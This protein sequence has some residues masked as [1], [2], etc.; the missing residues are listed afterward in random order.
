MESDMGRHLAEALVKQITG[1]DRVKV[2]RLYADPF[3]ILP[4]FKIFLSTNHRPHIRGSDKAIW[5]RLRLI[6]F[7]VV[8]PD[9]EQ[10]HRLL[11]T[12]ATETPG[13]LAWA[14][15]G[16]LVWQERGLEMPEEVR[17]ATA[18][19]RR[20]EDLLAD[21]LAERCIVDPMASVAAADLRAAYVDWAEKVGEKPL[22][23][24]SLGGHLKE[25]GFEQVRTGTLRG[26]VG[27]RLR[28]PM[29]SIP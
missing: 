16:C 27:V 6:P 3:E 20:D 7:T 4:A 1:G 5:R 10:D 22:S 12:L 9:D 15:R 28:R 17:D 19:Y 14:V 24:K 8:I 13:I 23:Q 2:R 18:A 26:W 11:E 21:F 25:C 29:E